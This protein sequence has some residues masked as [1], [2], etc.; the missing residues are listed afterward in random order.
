MTRD[1]K[2]S[3]TVLDALV[4]RLDNDPLAPEDI[5]GGTPASASRE[6]MT[7]RRS[8]IG[9]WELTPGTVTD[10][11]V[12]EVFVVLS[13]RAT[14]E[15]DGDDRVLDF[16]PGS[17]GRFSAGAR[18]RWTVTETLRKIYILLDAHEKEADR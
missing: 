11:E 18:T 7:W 17:I 4:L 12:D 14:V 1:L 13:G 2:A 6:L 10:I 8:S 16:G 5:I 9:V 15:V 3:N